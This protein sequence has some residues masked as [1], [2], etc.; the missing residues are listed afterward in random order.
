MPQQA[1][2]NSLDDVQVLGSWNFT[3]QAD[4]PLY[5]LK[6]GQ[7]DRYLLKFRMHSPYPSTA[8][9]VLHAE[10]DGPGSDGASFWVERRPSRDGKEGTRRYML[11]GDGLDS[12]PI[13]TRP[14]PDSGGE[15]L[16]DV[17]ILMEG[18]TGT[19]FLQDRK[20]HL[21]FRTKNNRG[22][23][24][25]YN[26]TQGEN[27]DVHFSS[28][29]ITALRRGPLEI[30]GKLLDRERKLERLA[31]EGKLGETTR[32][33]S[34][35]PVKAATTKGSFFGGSMNESRM[36]TMAPDSTAPRMASTTTVGGGYTWSNDELGAASDFRSTSMG[37][38]QFG[39]TASPGGRSFM[40]AG[41][42]K[43]VSKGRLQMSASD[44]ALRKTGSL[45]GGGSGGLTSSPSA[46]R[47]TFGATRSA[48]TAERWVP[49]ALNAPAGEQELLKSISQ[50]PH[51]NPSRACN[52]FI[53]M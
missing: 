32:S 33:E 38:Q 6:T 2:D 48:N 50:R 21:R 34:R 30:S 49:L 26:S 45:V 16:E 42:R 29:R 11:A 5:W 1:A 28:V 37:R 12:K 27:D 43:G 40:Q 39:S 19:I 10:V 35:S 31:D 9:I 53:A 17:E 47:K 41:G 51:K 14:F 24:A 44:G 3:L 22:S 25:F 46:M 8:G 7:L 18:Y 52:D 15:L 36:S 4:T 23:L 20:V 13:V